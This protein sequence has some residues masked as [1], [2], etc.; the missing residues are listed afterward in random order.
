MKTAAAFREF[1]TVL[2]A[3]LSSFKVYLLPLLYIKGIFQYAGAFS[4]PGGTKF[5]MAFLGTS[6]HSRK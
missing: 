6:E 1:D 5:S 2:V 3:G 4:P